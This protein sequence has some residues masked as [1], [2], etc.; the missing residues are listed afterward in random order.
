[1]KNNNKFDVLTKAIHS[2][3][4]KGYVIDEP[5]KK[6]GTILNISKPGREYVEQD[7]D[8]QLGFV[9]ESSNKTRYR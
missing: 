3:Q 9:F 8:N 2:V 1:M 6:N 4:S 7:F 5:N